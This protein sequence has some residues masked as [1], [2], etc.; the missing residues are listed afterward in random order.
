MAGKKVVKNIKV[1]I[2]AAGATPAPPLGPAL[3]QAGVNITNFVKEFNDR[4]KGQAG[5]R[6]VKIHTYEDRTYSFK[7]GSEMA[8]DLI[9]KEAG[10]TAG[11]A[12]PRQ[13][14]A[15]KITQA[16]LKKIA[17]AKMEHLN[18]QTVEQAMKIIAGSARS[19][20]IEVV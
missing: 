18:A 11:S 7:V 15:G 14:K 16:S 13:I 17:E 5:V 1:K 19:M 4:T 9:L 8:T 20:G 10:L 3:G 2:K 6:V 12:K